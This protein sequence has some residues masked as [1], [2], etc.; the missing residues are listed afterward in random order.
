[1]TEV[2]GVHGKKEIHRFVP[3]REI[4]EEFRPKDVERIQRRMNDSHIENI[5]TSITLNTSDQGVYTFTIALVGDERMLVDGQHRLE[6]LRRYVNSREDEDEKIALLNEIHVHVREVQ[7]VS[8]DRAVKLRDELG[9][10]IPVQPI[11]T[12]H[13]VRCQNLLKKFLT[14]CINT[15]SKAKNP[16]YGNWSE[17]FFDIVNQSSFFSHFSK[18]DEMLSEVLDL[19][20]YLFNNIVKQFKEPLFKF[21]T[22]GEKHDTPTFV[23]LKE[24]Y[25]TRAPESVMCLGLIVRY[26]FMEIILD[27]RDLKSSSYSDYFTKTIK[28]N[29]KLNFND[30]PSKED[31]KIVVRRFFGDGK[32]GEECRKKCPICGVSDLDS[33]IRSSFHLG[34]IVARAMGGKNQPSNLIPVCQRCNLDCRSQNLKEYC[35]N[36]FGREFLL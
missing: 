35:L 31:E 36:K 20:K 15:P 11:G 4:E 5:H 16:R 23:A 19:N 26:G 10:S 29:R 28:E 7:V 22:D 2:Y 24:R 32:I 6:A 13:G 3:L 18:A 9:T 1:M 21:I 14:E 25:K 34:H 33:D 8:E 17:S 27:K 12:V 30:S